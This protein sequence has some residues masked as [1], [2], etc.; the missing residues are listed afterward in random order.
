MRH[1]RSGWALTSPTPAGAF[2]VGTGQASTAN[3]T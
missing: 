1:S 2:L 3:T